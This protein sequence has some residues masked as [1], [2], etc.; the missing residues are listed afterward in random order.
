MHI[1]MIEGDSLLGSQISQALA[2]TG[3]TVSWLREGRSA[4]G[5]LRTRAADLTLLDLDIA[6][7]N[8]IDLVRQA[9]QARADTPML[10]M[11]SCDD[12]SFRVDALDA[13]AD[14]L[15]V[16]PFHMEE[17]A[18]RIR[19]LV[20]RRRGFA[21]NRIEVGDLSLD[22][23]TSEVTLRGEKVIL[24]RRELALLQSLVG[25]AGRLVPR[26]SLEDCIYGLDSDVGN[27]AIEVLVHALRRKLGAD[28]IRNVRGFG[29][30]IPHAP[31]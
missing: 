29:Y 31:K 10:V 2:R 15:L 26:G 30:L 28:T 25:R 27:N 9:R 24:T 17:L 4:L 8:G 5:A 18:A 14:D 3:C 23:G 1:L 16:R 11:S 19:S 20:R 12:L 13:G 7:R 6:A 22:L 21:V